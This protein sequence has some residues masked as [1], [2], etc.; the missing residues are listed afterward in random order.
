[1]APHPKGMPPS[2]AVRSIQSRSRRHVNPDV[3]SPVHSNDDYGIEKLEADRRGNEQ[4]HGSDVRRVITQESAPSLTGS[5]LPLGTR[6]GDD[7]Q[8]RR[9]PPI[10]LDKEQAIAIRETRPFARL[11]PQ[12]NQL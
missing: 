12:D 4:V 5:A 9:K 8:D 2:S 7:L 10:Q 6:D 1:M 11:T 3:L